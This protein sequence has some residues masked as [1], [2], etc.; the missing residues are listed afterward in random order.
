LRSGRFSCGSTDG[1]WLGRA[2]LSVVG[3]VYTVNAAGIGVLWYTVLQKSAFHV[4]ARVHPAQQGAAVALIITLI[5][6]ARLAAPARTCTPGGPPPPAAARLAFAAA[7]GAGAWFGLLA[8]SGS[9]N[10]LRWLPFGVPIAIAA[11]EVAV[12]VWSLRRWSARSD[13]QVLASAPAP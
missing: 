3:A 4:P 6:L 11:A 5:L 2:G 13:L 7:A 10:H 9:G 12:A 1:P 8:L